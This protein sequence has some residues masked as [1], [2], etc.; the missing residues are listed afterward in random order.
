MTLQGAI[1]QLHDLRSD[2][3]FPFY[4]K[5]A[6]DKVIETILT[7]AQEVRHGRWIPD[8]GGKFKGGAYWFRCSRCGRTVPDVRNGGWDYCPSCGS[9]MVE[10]GTD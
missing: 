2:D 1:Q 6:I 10:D 8:F 4:Y 5:P 7:D 9:R 3:N